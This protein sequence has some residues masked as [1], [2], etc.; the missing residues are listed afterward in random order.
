MHAVIIGTSQLPR[1][2]HRQ[3]GSPLSL[4]VIEMNL[5]VRSTPWKRRTSTAVLD[6]DCALRIKVVLGD[7]NGNVAMDNACCRT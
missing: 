2:K 3:T 6:I 7:I 1:S 5:G 4:I